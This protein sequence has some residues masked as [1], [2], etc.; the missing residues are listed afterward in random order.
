MKNS[1]SNI[2]LIPLLAALAIYLPFSFTSSGPDRR[3]QEQPQ[4]PSLM[5]MGT[6]ATPTPTPTPGR[7]SGEAARLLCDFFALKPEPDRD[8]Q[9]QS[10]GRKQ[11]Q[12][13]ALRDVDPKNLKGDYCRVKSIRDL[14]RLEYLGA[15]DYKIEYIIATLPDPIDSRLDYMFDRNLDAIQRAI[16]EA[17]YTFDRYSLPWD[18]NSAASS[19]VLPADPNTTQTPARHLYEPGVILFRGRDRLSL[20]FLF[21]VGETPT[22]GINQVAFQNALRQ[23]EELDDWKRTGTIDETAE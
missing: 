7:V 19:V 3:S 8:T 10:G 5:R 4:S 15:Y 13:E 22:G 17:G 11:D 14:T 16:A 6:L 2:Y 20:L 9:D 1:D 23:I 18:R 12:P 21:L